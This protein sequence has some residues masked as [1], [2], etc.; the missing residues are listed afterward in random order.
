MK[1][2]TDSNMRYQQNPPIYAPTRP[3]M[4]VKTS[5]KFSNKST[6]DIRQK[7]M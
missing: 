1:G 5:N 7:H 6:E 3:N 2:G 4:Y